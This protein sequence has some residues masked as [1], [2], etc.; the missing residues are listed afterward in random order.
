MEQLIADSIKLLNSE[1]IEIIY[2]WMDYGDLLNQKLRSND[3][4]N[5][6]D[7]ELIDNII[8]LISQVILTD[9]I[10]VYRGL[11][12]STLD[13][14]TKQFNSVTPDQATALT[15]GDHIMKIV[16]P[17]GTNIFYISAWEHITTD[18]IPNDEKEILLPPG[19]F[20]LSDNDGLYKFN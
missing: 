18:S 7:S 19:I 9:E 3:R 20:N 16:I 2:A 14:N 13:N 5:N 17:K 4:L 6:I 12:N 1:T 10:I 15:Y 8:K 11:T